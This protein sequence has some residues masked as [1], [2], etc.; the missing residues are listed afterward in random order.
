MSPPPDPE[1]LPVVAAEAHPTA[2][3]YQTE[4]FQFVF[5]DDSYAQRVVEGLADRAEVAYQR[6][7]EWF[8]QPEASPPM[9]RLYLV[10]GDV[11]EHDVSDAV[12]VSPELP[13]LDLDWLIMRGVVRAPHA[14]AV[15]A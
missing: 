1:M 14:G 3:E 9:L 10:D 4:H 12:V 5:A 7:W 6:S 15:R 8:G 13:A 11:L 2:R